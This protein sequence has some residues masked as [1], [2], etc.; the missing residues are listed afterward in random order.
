VCLGSYL[1]LDFELETLTM[2]KQSNTTRQA[3]VEV[4]LAKLARELESTR[5]R[6]AP[7]IT[8][9]EWTALHYAQQVLQ[10]LAKLES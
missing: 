6:V 4:D 10:N 7:F 1:H 8:D 2:T 9:S 3:T 5:E